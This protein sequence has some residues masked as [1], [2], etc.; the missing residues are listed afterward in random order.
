MQELR[1]AAG[2]ELAQAQVSTLRECLLKIGVRVAC[3]VRRIVL[4]LPE[5]FPFAQAWGTVASSL[6]ASSG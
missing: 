5:S 3:S 6:G 2:P 1:G 4:Y